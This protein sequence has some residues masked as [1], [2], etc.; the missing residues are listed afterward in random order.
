MEIKQVEHVKIVH[1]HA[2]PAQQVLIV[3][4]VSPV[5]NSQYKTMFVTHTAVLLFNIIME[6]YVTHHA[7]LE[8]I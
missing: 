6:E 7:Q 2:Q 5:P 4:H 3:A 8:H 1:L